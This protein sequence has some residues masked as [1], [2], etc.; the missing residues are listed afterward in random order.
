MPQEAILTRSS[1]N[2]LKGGGQ[3]A[4]PETPSLGTFESNYKMAASEDERLIRTI[5]REK[6]EDCEQSNNAIIDCN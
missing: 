5:L 6:R 2:Y 1:L 3:F 4:N